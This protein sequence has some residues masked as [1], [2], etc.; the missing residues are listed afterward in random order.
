MVGERIQRKLPESDEIF[1]AELARLGS[2]TAMAREYGCSRGT[3]HQRAKNIQRRGVVPELTQA[4]TPALEAAVLQIIRRN[5]ADTRSLGQRLQATPD[6]I[7]DAMRGLRRSGYE[8]QELGGQ[9]ML[10]R[11]PMVL[12]SEIRRIGDYKDRIIRF[13]ACSDSHYGSS[14]QQRTALHDFYR[15]CA[16]LEIEHVFNSG[17]LLAGVNMYPEQV[18]EVYLHGSDKQVDAVIADYPTYPGCTTHIIG[19][20][21]D[22]SFLK[23]AG[24]DVFTRISEQR[25][26]LDFGGWYEATFELGPLRVKLWHP[27]GGVPYAKSYR[28]QR[29]SEGLGRGPQVPH[30][31]LMGHLHQALRMEHQSVHQW[32]VPCCEGSNAWGRRLGLSPAIGGWIITILMSEDGSRIEAIS[33]QQLIYPELQRDWVQ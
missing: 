23:A 24:L 26:D 30:I 25:P 13:S 20:N 8:V 21:H 19:G 28:L 11:V 27:A 16:E 15:R 2:N 1:L 12:P 4:S 3:V 32:L 14:A 10:I 33:D 22:A 5:P 29:L 9:W 17:D 31:I 18:Y 7:L 6:A